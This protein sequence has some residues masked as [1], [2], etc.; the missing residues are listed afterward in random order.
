MEQ[1]KQRILQLKENIKNWSHAYYVDNTSIV[2]DDIFDQA[3]KELQQ[4]EKEYPDLLDKDSPT[5]VVQG[6]ATVGYEKVRHHEPM[7]SLKTETD[8]TEQG[9]KDFVSRIEKELKE[10]EVKYVAE[11]KYDG[12]G[13][14]LFYIGQKLVAAV[15]RGD[16]EYGENV[17]HNVRHIPSIPTEVI[18]DAPELMYVRGEIVMD[19]KGFIAINEDLEAKGLKPLANP[20]NAA[21]GMIRRQTTDMENIGKL[22]FLAYSMI[23]PNRELMRI[24]SQSKALAFM[25]KLGFHIGYHAFMETAKS[26]W[27]FHEIVTKGRDAL[28]YDIDGV[29]YKV[30]SYYQQGR[31]GF[32]AREPRWAVAH[33]FPPQEARSTLLDID[34]QV[35]MTGAVTPVARITPVYVGG[36]TVSNVTLHNAFD[37]RERG[38][39]IGDEVIVRRAGDVI[40]EIVKNPLFKREGYSR[41]FWIP[42]I[43]P[44][45]GGPVTRIKGERKYYCNNGTFCS[46][47]VKERI[48][49]FASRRA[50][51][52]MGL[53][54][55]LVAQLHDNKL[56]EHFADIFSLRNEQLL[57]LEG[58]EQ[59]KADNLINSIET[60]K[61]V[62][63]YKFLY[64][65]GIRHVGEET[66][67]DICKKFDVRDIPTLDVAALMSI[68]GVGPTTALSVVEYFENDDNN[69]VFQEL[70]VSGLVFE[71]EARSGTALTGSTFVVTG[72]FG[73]VSRDVIK[74]LIQNN[75][76]RFSGV[77]GKGTSYLIAG[78][79]G[80]SKRKE[81]EKFGVEVI[82]LDTFL[83]FLK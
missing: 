9:A 34:V 53:G 4:L 22:R 3:F 12:L 48:R 76:G 73:D 68:E 38:V 35:G 65:L 80:G 21:A 28:D 49:H 54:E 15:T 75:G 63:S 30:D 8:Y 16:G 5:Q 14:D 46:A 61:N 64:A 70:L 71:E 66:A 78:E 44:C 29:V 24:T 67:R 2:S 19:K 36:V 17:L 57:Q 27:N 10:E 11:L 18:S 42:R 31:L 62:K 79:G 59:K 43:C 33:K 77:I 41:N 74:E 39:R 47:Q 60:S 81:A 45:C 72:S 55:K 40:P 13:M 56:I 6:I 83:S 51:N 52:I 7:L 32:V 20:R 82:T 1:I 23:D 37:L 69:A 58:F 26:L 50:M 25:S